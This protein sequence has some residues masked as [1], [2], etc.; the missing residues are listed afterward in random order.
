[1]LFKIQ[2]SGYMMKKSKKI[3]IVV[4]AIIVS[5]VIAS[6]WYVNDYYHAEGKENLIASTDTV[7]VIK[8]DFGYTFDGP[9]EGTGVIF[10]PGAKV[11]D[12]SYANL[13][14]SIAEKGVDCYLVSMPCNIAFFGRNKADKVMDEYDNTS[15]YMAGHSLGGL[16]AS[17][18]AKD[19]SDKIDGLILLASY[20]TTDISDTD[21]KVLSVY[22]SE[23]KVVNMQSVENCRANMPKSYTEFCIEGGNHSEFGDY[24][25]Q[26]GDGQATISGQE[27]KEKTA[28]YIVELIN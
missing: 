19:N 16:V 25:M 14:K 7:D 23:D 18:Y 6:V 13:M 24:G 11:E 20:S 1:M 17:E 12:I 22:G 28:K 21:L 4:L 3:M 27:Q 2:E 15:W 9:G 26:K 5:L 8:T 10:Y